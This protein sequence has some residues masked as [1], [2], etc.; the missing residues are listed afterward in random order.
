MKVKP[1][2]GRKEKEWKVT[3]RDLNHPSH[4][5]GV[6]TWLVMLGVPRAEIDRLVR[7]PLPE[8]EALSR[9]TAT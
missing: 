2:R 4:E 3:E 9:E 6:R 7:E 5:A 8:K 1:K